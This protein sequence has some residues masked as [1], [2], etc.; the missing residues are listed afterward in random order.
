VNVVRIA[1]LSLESM[2]SEQRRIYD[3]IIARLGRL[4]AP[5]IAMLRSPGLADAV[6]KVGKF[7]RDDSSLSLRLIEL[8]V[9]FIARTW[10]ADRVWHSH[11]LL[12]R[13]A[14]ID[15]DMISAIA[16]R[17]KPTFIRA[18]EEVVYRLCTELHEHRAVNESTY[19]AAVKQLGV[20]GVVELVALLG[21]YTLAAMMVKT[22][23]LLPPEGITDV[24]PQ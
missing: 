18:D 24:L 16:E 12:A 14:G 1:E 8:A 2:T 19:Q 7:L 3:E 11:A 6:N 9:L 21:H 17:Q 23:E 10:T 4:G 13:E 15:Q 5:Y 20:Q 22:F